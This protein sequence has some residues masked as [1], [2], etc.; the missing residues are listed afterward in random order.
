MSD[1]R[2][3]HQ[4]NAWYTVY[5]KKRKQLL[6]SL[7]VFACFIAIVAIGFFA[8]TYTISSPATQQYISAFGYIGAIGVAF[9]AGLNVFIPLP[10]ATFTPLFVASGFHL[11]G[12]VLAFTAGTVLADYVGYVIG[13]FG[14]DTIANHHPRTVRTLEKIHQNHRPWILPVMF[15]YAAFAPLPNEALVIP[16]ALLGI[17]WQHMILPLIFGNL[18]N[19]TIYAYG[20]QNIFEWLM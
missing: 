4:K 12:L 20:I 5:M 9:V 14:R 13:K 3:H 2:Q 1:R 8:A 7:I 18:I 19:Q 11:P 16:L 6:S 10:V 17:K 15:L